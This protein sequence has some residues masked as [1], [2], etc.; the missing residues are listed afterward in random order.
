MRFDRRAAIGLSIAVV[1]LAITLTTSYLMSVKNRPTL[2]GLSEELRKGQVVAQAARVLRNVPPGTS[3]IKHNTLLVAAPQRVTTLEAVPKPGY[4]VLSRGPSLAQ[5]LD[6]AIAH[7]AR[8]PRIGD[9][10]AFQD[11]EVQVFAVS[12]AGELKRLDTTYVTYIRI[13]DSTAE[14]NEFR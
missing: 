3:V 1:A 6:L 14:V 5:W 12:P 13:L 2:E 4:L 11:T 10:Y 7:K 8:D 9:G